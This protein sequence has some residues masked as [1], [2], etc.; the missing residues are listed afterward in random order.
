MNGFV[1]QNRLIALA[2]SRFVRQN[3]HS[4]PQKIGFVSQNAPTLLPVGQFVRQNDLSLEP[5]IGF[6]SQ[7]A[8]LQ[9]TAEAVRTAKSPFMRP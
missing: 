1:S 6:V 8:A 4:R 5:K 7:N 9:L 2:P 3:E